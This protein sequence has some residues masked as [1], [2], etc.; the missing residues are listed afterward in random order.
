MR[1]PSVFVPSARRGTTILIV[2]FGSP[3]ADADIRIFDLGLA[4]RMTNQQQGI[5]AP[6]FTQLRSG[7]G[8][9]TQADRIC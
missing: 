6:S 1:F 8:K 3:A 7:I 9:L 2:V 5:K 4:A